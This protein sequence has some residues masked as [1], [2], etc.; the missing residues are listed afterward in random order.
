V[1]HGPVSGGT[2]GPFRS[3]L[4]C[5]FPEKSLIGDP[6]HAMSHLQVRSFVLAFHSQCSSRR[7]IWSGMTPRQASSPITAALM[8]LNIRQNPQLSQIRRKTGMTRPSGATL[9]RS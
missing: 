5:P 1:G 7:Y 6:D 8:A 3:P 4:T 2:N 9:P